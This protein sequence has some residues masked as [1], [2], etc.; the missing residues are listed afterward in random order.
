MTP[1]HGT[2]LLIGLVAYVLSACGT[3]ALSVCDSLPASGTV[4]ES[5]SRSQDEPNFK[6][7]PKGFPLPLD[8][9]EAKEAEGGGGK[10]LTY[11]V[12]RGSE[13]VVK[14]LRGFLKQEAWVIDSDKTSP[15]GAIRLVVT[16]NN[17]TIK[18]SIV[19]DER[20]TVLV[21]TLP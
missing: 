3:S 19:G 14:E 13:L 7:G 8:S 6:A 10:I 9:G 16:K 5:A 18:V 17:T 20:Q 1:H 2:A 11:Q 15:R 4:A 21:L 12:P